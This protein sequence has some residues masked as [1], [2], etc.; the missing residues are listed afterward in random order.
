MTVQVNWDTDGEKIEN[1]PDTV[2]VPI[3]IDTED[4][5]DWLSDKYGWCVLSW[6]EVT[7]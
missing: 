7:Q 6:K 1:L 3:G 4:V 5:A 2:Q